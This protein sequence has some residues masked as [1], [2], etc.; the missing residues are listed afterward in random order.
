M[1]RIYT[2][3]T[4]GNHRDLYRSLAKSFDSETHHRTLSGAVRR[5]VEIDRKSRHWVRTTGKWGHVEIDVDGEELAHDDVG[6]VQM[7]ISDYSRDHTELHARIAAESI[8]QRS[9]CHVQP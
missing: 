7:C 8:L 3:R 6:Y 4:I 9:C 5:L 1:S 2:I